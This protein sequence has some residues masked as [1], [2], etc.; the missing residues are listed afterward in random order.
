MSSDKYYA[1]RNTDYTKE[2][3]DIICE[4]IADGESLRKIC[5]DDDMPSKASVFRWLYEQEA[6]RDQY[7]RAR[8][9]Q[10][11]TFADE[12]TDIADEHGTKTVINVDGEEVIVAYDSVAVARNKLRVDT[13]KWI[14][15][16]VKPKKYGE[17]VMLA[18]SEGNNLPAPQFIITP[19]TVKPE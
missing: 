12:M 1:G 15:A 8:E 5:L 3:G 10:T 9:E 13:R 2:T 19:V 17:K 4:R 18:D 14:M 7:A 6:F 11:E 16:K